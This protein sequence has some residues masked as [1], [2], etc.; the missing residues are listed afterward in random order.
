MTSQTGLQ[1]DQQVAM[2]L[3]PIAFRGGGDFVDWISHSESVSAINKWTDEEKLLWLYIR[4]TREAHSAFTCLS[5]MIHQL[6]VP[7][8]EALLE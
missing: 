1:T 3:L 7:I 2:V 8:K 6:H 4:K 5:H